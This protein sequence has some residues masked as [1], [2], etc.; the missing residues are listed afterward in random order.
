M[1][2]L[3]DQILNLLDIQLAKNWKLDIQLNMLVDQILNLLDIQPAKSQTP[4][5]QLNM[6]FDQILDILSNICSSFLLKWYVKNS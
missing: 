3:V 6:L 5:I 4:D 2:M 1:N